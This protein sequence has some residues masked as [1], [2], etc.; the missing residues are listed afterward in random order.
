[1]ANAKV[2]AFLSVPALSLLVCP[3][4]VLS[5]PKSSVF[6]SESE[7]VRE[8]N[9]LIQAC[10]PRNFSLAICSDGY[11]RFTPSPKAASTT[12][13]SRTSLLRPLGSTE[14]D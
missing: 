10:Y 3:P 2:H 13:T 4:E 11:T 8:V 9:S 14:E 6:G 12:L 1:M 7:Y 5:K